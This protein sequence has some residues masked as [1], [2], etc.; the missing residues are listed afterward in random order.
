M[1][2]LHSLV[3]FMLRFLH[4]YLLP[5]LFTLLV[6]EEAGVPLPVAQRAVAPARG[7]AGVWMA[8]RGQPG[9][10]GR[11]Q[12]G[13]RR[14]CLAALSGDASLGPSALAAVREVAAYRPTAA[15]AHGALV[16]PP[17]APGDH[18]GSFHPRHARPDYRAGR[19]ERHPLSSL[20]PFG[21]SGRTALVA[22]LLLARRA[23]GTAGTTLVGAADD[24]TRGGA[25]VVAGI[26]PP[27]GWR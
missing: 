18:R 4:T 12:P 11:L 19:A 24:G 6:I 15:R 7:H 26:R 25:H 13:R 21:G 10:H 20:C 17:P 3:P 22:G 1:S 9:R 2:A 5:A 27:D 14:R 23:P 8:Y 16:R